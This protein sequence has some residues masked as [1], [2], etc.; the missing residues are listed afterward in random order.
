MKHLK[1]V[2]VRPAL[3]SISTLIQDIIDVITS[4]IQSIIDLLNAFFRGA[5]S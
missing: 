4:A 5:L 3:S 1:K 2:T